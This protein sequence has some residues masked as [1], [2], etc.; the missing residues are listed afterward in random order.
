MNST[1][2]PWTQFAKSANNAL[3][4]PVTIL[5]NTGL[6]AVH[7][8]I[9]GA[10]KVSEV[11]T[12]AAVAG[13]L[14]MAEAAEDITS[15][16]TDHLAQ[17]SRQGI[18]RAVDNICQAIDGNPNGSANR[19]L[20]RTLL[21]DSARTAVLPV[22]AVASATIGRAWFKSALELMSRGLDTLSAEGVLPDPITQKLAAQ[23]RAGMIECAFGG[24]LGAITRDFSGMAGGLV[25][26]LLGDTTRL[27]GGAQAFRGS[28]Q[29]VY[30]KK[31][32]GEVQPES[33]F[34]IKEKLVEH[35]TAV[36]ERY[37]EKWVEALKREDLWDIATAYLRNPVAA[38]TLILRYPRAT[39]QVLTGVMV[40]VGLHGFFQ[41][42]D[43]YSYSLC[44]LAII[45]S[46]LADEEKDW[47]L[48]R[49]RKTA[50]KSSVGYEYYIPLLVPF[51]GEVKDKAY[52]RDA[53]GE[54]IDDRGSS[55]SVFPKRSIELAQALTSELV[56]LRALLWLYGDEQTARE[57]NQ[58]ETTRKFGPG[59]A[60]RIEENPR[61]P[62]TLE[63][64]GELSSGRRTPQ[65]V[66][67]ILD[68]VLRD[69]GLL[70]IADAVRRGAFVPGELL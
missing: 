48:E 40:F 7:A 13:R 26:L 1:E 69:R 29:Y 45:D 32:Q 24:P 23:L 44:E 56:S 10:A 8:A 39:Y 15:S 66:D 20:A 31:L 6:A 16:F 67:G 50:P 34:P 53:A 57:K 59:P 9:G 22:S 41:V 46:R 19:L 60:R 14:P 51:D 68:D 61:F 5:A 4:A 58:R 70:T 38:N 43:S 49:L 62:L 54:I 3:L 18:E 33:D 36:I 35:A 42:E 21:D 28:M 47:A 52:R 27:A 30:E 25:A 17:G 65:E 55:P 2:S 37:P 11:A 64:I 63:E 12:R